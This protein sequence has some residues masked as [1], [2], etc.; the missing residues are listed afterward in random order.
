MVD[1][2]L[3]VGNGIDHG[4]LPQ[5]GPSP[6][7]TMLAVGVSSRP[8]RLQYL[9]PRAFSPMPQQIVQLRQISASIPCASW[10]RR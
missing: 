9:P 2:R 3:P 6:S 7:F 10:A 4:H 8:G 1:T 5:D